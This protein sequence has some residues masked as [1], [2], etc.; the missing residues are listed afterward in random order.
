MMNE[1]GRAALSARTSV[2]VLYMI[3]R[4]PAEHVLGSFGQALLPVLDLIGVNVELLGKLSQSAFAL[5][6][7]QCNLRLEGR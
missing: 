7:C 4:I 6:G 5:Q 3:R 1:S 2:T